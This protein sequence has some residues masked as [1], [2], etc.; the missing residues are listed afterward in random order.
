[1]FEN[2]TYEYLLEKALE[3]VPNDMDKREGSV[4]YDAIAPAMAELADAY[5]YLEMTLNEAFGITATYHYLALRAYE[6][7]MLP[8]PASKAVLKGEFTPREVVIK[9]GTRFR[10]EDA[11]YIVLEKIEDGVYKLECEIEGV[12]GNQQFGALIPIDYIEGLKTAELTEVLIAGIEEETEEHFRT[13][14]FSL[15]QKPSTSG[16]K[17]DYYN[18]AMQ[19]IGVGAVKVFPLAFGAGTVKLVIADNDKRQ[20]SEELLKKVKE[21]IEEVRPIGAMI[22]VVSVQEKKISV[23]ANIKLKNGIVLG[24]VQ[25]DFKQ[26]LNEYF[27]QNSFDMTYVSI[28]KLGNILLDTIGVEDY[29]DLKLNN[30]T[31]N[32]SLEQEEVAVVGTVELGVI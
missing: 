24:S 12:K 17:Y 32:I 2:M 10:L 20:A 16:N 14:Y 6:S 26:L 22:S 25:E 27:S 21:H 13:R 23:T 29:S 18:W 30:Q 4:I 3:K 31:G 7:G 19:C 9:E 5:T 11:T 8:Y 28:A 15:I 1:M